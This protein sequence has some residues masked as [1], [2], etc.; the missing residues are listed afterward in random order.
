VSTV[1]GNAAN[2]AFATVSG[3]HNAGTLPSRNSSATTR[4][5]S[6]HTASIG[7]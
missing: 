6:A 1:G 2:A 5:I 7:W 4:F 3:R